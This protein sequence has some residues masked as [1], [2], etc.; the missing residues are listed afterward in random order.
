MMITN[1][2][3]PC[4]GRFDMPLALS[5]TT[6]NDLGTR[7]RLAKGIGSG[8]HRIPQHVPDCVVYRQFPGDVVPRRI[9]DERR[10]GRL[11]S[12]EPQ[13]HLAGAS[14]LPHFREHQIHCILHAPVRI[15]FD[16][17]VVGPPEA[18]R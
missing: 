12:A 18:H 1:Q 13:Q 15:H 17:A 4:F 8:V 11:L 16:F 5:R 9:Q 3:R 6:I 14:Q 10:Q 7:L 2:D